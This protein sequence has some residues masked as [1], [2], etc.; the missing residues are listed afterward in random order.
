MK[1]RWPISP[2]KI[3]IALLTR[4]LSEPLQVAL[5]EGDSLKKELAHYEK[6]K[7]SLHNA[8]ARLKV[9]EEKYKQSTWEHEVLEQRF[10]QVQKERDELYEQFVERII[11][12]QQKTGFKNLV[13][14]CL[15]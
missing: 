14:Y 3:S 2:P 10:A 4:R 9:L 5:A 7:L 6:D 1:N 15:Y 13:I 12:V 8:K 11:N